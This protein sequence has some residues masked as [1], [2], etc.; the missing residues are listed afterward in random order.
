MVWQHALAAAGRAAQQ[1]RFVLA[2][3]LLR[4]AHHSPAT[5]VHAMT[6]GTSHLHAHPDDA[7]AREGVTIL[8]TAIAFL[9]IKPRTDDIAVAQR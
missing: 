2:L 1:D 9:G 4:A 7:L 3:D 6:L 5:M 8:E